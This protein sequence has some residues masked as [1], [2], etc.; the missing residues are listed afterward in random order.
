[1]KDMY[2]KSLR[3]SDKWKGVFIPVLLSFGST[4]I[5]LHD[6][7][8]NELNIHSKETKKSLWQKKISLENLTGW[9][10]KSPCLN[11]MINWLQSHTMKLKN[12][13]CMH[14]SNYSRTFTLIKSQLDKMSEFEIIC[15]FLLIKYPLSQ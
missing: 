8:I 13:A 3:I 11:P 1:M 15:P 9:P 4:N 5:F 12:M 7:Q 6:I 10:S 14:K 2:L